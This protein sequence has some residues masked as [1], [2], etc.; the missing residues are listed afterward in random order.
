M[1]ATELFHMLNRMS[2]DDLDSTVVEVQNEHGEVFS[3]GVELQGCRLIF[4]VAS[5]EHPI[6]LH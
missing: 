5:N 6:L 1:I 4:K 2:N 3:C